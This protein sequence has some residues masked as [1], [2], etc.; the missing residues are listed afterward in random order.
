MIKDILLGVLANYPVLAAMLAAGSW[1]KRHNYY[2]LEVVIGIPFMLLDYL[3]QYTWG[4]FLF[5]EWPPKGEHTFSGRIRRYRRG[6]V[7]GT[8]TDT[9]RIAL[10]EYFKV[11]LNKRLPGHIDV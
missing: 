5:R 7:D 3:F 2:I 11:Y 6:I 10:T 8:I 4:V 1:S 9:E